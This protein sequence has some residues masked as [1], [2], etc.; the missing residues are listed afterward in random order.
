MCVHDAA[1]THGQYLALSKAWWC[2]LFISMFV[3][4]ITQK[5]GGRFGWNVQGRL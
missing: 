5:V 4:R 2:C 3:R 1:A